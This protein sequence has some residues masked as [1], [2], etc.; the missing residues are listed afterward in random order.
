M[1]HRIL[2]T[3]LVVMGLTC[4]WGA[5]ADTFPTDGYMQENKI[6]ESAATEE[7]LGAYEG[8]VNATAEYDDILYQILAGSYLPA[9]SEGDVETC[10]AGSYCPG[11]TDATYNETSAQGVTSCP[12]GYPNSE[13]GAGAQTQCY[14]ACTTSTANIA[15]ATAVSGNDYYGAGVDTCVAT[16]CENGYHVSDGVKLIERDPLI[17]V[18]ASVLGNNYGY[19]SAD[20]ENTQRV[21][22]NGLTENNTWASEF[23]YGTVYGRAS[24]QSAI[25]SERMNT[26]LGVFGDVMGGTMSA[27][28]M[29]TTFE[30]VAGTA[31]TDVLVSAYETYLA[32]SKTD[33]D[34]ESFFK[35]VYQLFGIAE[36]ADYSTTD[37]GQYCYCQMTDYMPAGGD[38][39]KVMSAPWVF[40][41][42][43]GSADN[44]ADDCARNC[45]SYLHNDDT[46][47]RVFRG[48]VFGSLGATAAG[49]CD[50]NEI[51]I[52]WTDA[53]PADVSA[54]NAGMC[55]F[56]GDIRTPVRAA[57]KPGKTFKG[58]KFDNAK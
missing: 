14:T 42:D 23:D 13:S 38:K 30:P 57:T 55:T 37:S 41:G 45:A 31:T 44:C 43:Y 12:T 36:G 49:T 7:N 56:G 52:T 16:A 46:L 32:S 25:H 35:V 27:E 34:Q 17:D 29:R 9:G 20:G 8:T 26:F 6:Y 50:A 40:L 58:W 21:S 28:D 53:D 54:N 22:E 5:R 4:P 48:A 19:I 24:C 51:E 18:D 3:S 2:L 15:H 10:P 11:V 47:Y 33:S 39:S 1:K